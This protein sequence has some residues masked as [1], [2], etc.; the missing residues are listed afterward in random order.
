[1]PRS[2]LKQA[3]R[4]KGLTQQ[5]IA[6]YLYISLPHYKN[7]ESGKR[8]GSFEIWDMLED[9]LSSH[10]RVLRQCFDSEG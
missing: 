1:M 3:R 5:E 7:I 10:Q 4:D 2:I 8:I 9:L 6:E